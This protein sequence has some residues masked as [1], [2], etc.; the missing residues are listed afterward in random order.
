MTLDERVTT[1][2]KHDRE[3]HALDAA[4]DEQIKSLFASV[5]ILR[6][7]VYGFAF[8]ML[9]ALIYGAVGPDGF[10][11]VTKAAPIPISNGDKIS[12]AIPPNNDLKWWMLRQAA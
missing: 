6:N 1:L 11:A 4:Q 2:E 7:V 3:Q 9:L 5:K 8:I 10:R 12:Y